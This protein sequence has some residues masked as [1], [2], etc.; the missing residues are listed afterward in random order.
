MKRD[1]TTHT[2]RVFGRTF[3]ECELATLS[4]LGTLGE[5]RIKRMV[6]YP[7]DKT[8][9]CCIETIVREVTR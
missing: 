7:V 5:V 9:E 3:D 1:V 2:L 4:I 8:G 6:Y